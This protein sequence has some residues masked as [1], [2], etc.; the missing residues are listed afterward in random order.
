M[1][2]MLRPSA[3]RG[4]GSLSLSL[5]LSLP[6]SLFSPHPCSALLCSLTLLRCPPLR[7]QFECRS[8]TLYRSLNTNPLTLHC[9]VMNKRRSGLVWAVQ[10]SHNNAFFSLV[11]GSPHVTKERERRGEEEG[12]DR[13]GQEG[14]GARS[15]RRPSE[16]A[17]AGRHAE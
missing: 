1:M 16:M 12:Q 4:G 15:G 10:V 2:M 8:S 9:L 17:E 13:A 3:H 5:P 14:W 6:V 7:A 11:I